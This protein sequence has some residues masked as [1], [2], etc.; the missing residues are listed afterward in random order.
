MDCATLLYNKVC[1][2]MV[3]GVADE[4]VLAYNQ[5]AGTVPVADTEIKIG[6]VLVF[7]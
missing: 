3:V 4:S 1:D 5:P 6:D 7:V 2:T